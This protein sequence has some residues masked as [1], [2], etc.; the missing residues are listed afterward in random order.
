MMD[1]DGAHQQPGGLVI[2][3]VNNMPAAA[4]RD[5]ERQFRGLLAALDVRVRLIVSEGLLLHGDETLRLLEEA[6]PDGLIVT[7]AEPQS[8]AMTAEPFWPGLVRLVDWAGAHTI[9]SVWSCLAAH[10]AVFRLDQIRRR[11]LPRKLSGVFTCMKAAEAHPLLAELPPRWT[12]PHS[13]FNGLDDADLVGAGYSVLSHAPEV[14]ADAFVKQSGSSLFVLMQGHPEYGAGS[15]LGEYRRDVRR[16]L[17]GQRRDYPD[18]PSGYFDAAAAEGLERLRTEALRRP[19][20]DLLA[21]F[22]AAAGAA[23]AATWH[24]PAVRL[25]AGWLGYLAARKADGSVRRWRVAS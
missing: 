15:L 21:G 4:R 7:G 2:G 22:D 13:R 18:M 23:P 5:T 12:V 25:Y 8:E 9:S 16:F 24:E 3:L 10:A 11:K 20:L 6:R 1:G 19:R 14:G 17:A